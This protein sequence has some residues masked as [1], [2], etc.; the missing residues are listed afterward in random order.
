MQ[1]SLTGL[2]SNFPTGQRDVLCGDQYCL[3]TS[4]R[5][6]ASGWLSERRDTDSVAPVQ[7]LWLVLKF[8]DECVD[9]G[10]IVFFDKCLAKYVSIVGRQFCYYV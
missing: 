2:V 10:T 1:G 7:K 3:V 5:R 8:N 4:Q 9:C 6:T